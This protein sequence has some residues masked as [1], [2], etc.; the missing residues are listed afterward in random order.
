MLDPLKGAVSM[1]TF[2]S[3]L[4]VF[5]AIVV[6]QFKVE[7]QIYGP[8]YYGPNGDIQYQ[9]YLHW[10]Q[11]LQYLQQVDPYYELHAMHYQLYLPPSQTYG[12]Y[13]PCCS[14]IWGFA[15]QYRAF[16]YAARR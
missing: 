5:V 10:Q 12:V 4:L 2:L 14:T 9:H 3:A 1:K 7:A 8:Y 11:H 13:A 15:P 6:G 16:H